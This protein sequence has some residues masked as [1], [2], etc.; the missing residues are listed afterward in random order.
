M[1]RASRA[2]LAA[3]AGLA[4][5]G[6]L[7]LASI[8]RTHPAG[9][10][11]HL[12][13][14]GRRLDPAAETPGSEG[15]F[16]R[17]RSQAAQVSVESVWE[18][19]QQ[20]S[21][22]VYGADDPEYPAAFRH[23]PEPP[24]VIFVQGD[25][26]LL[27]A[28]RR[29]GVVGTRNATAA[30]RAT[31][32][33]LG[34]SLADHGV[35]VVSGLALG[36]DAA[37]HRGLRAGDGMPVGVVANGL[38][39]PYP[40]Q[41]GD[42]WHWVGSRGVLISERPPGCPPE[43]WRFPLRNRLIAALSEVLVVVESRERGGS[44][45]TVEQAL[46]RGVSVMAVPGSPRCR[47]AH[48]TNRLLVEGAGPVTCVEDVLVALGIDH[49]RTAEQLALPLA[50][51]V[52][53]AIELGILRACAACPNTLDMLAAGIGCSVSEVALAVMRLVREGRVQDDDGWFEST[54]SR[55]SPPSVAGSGVG[56][57]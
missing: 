38:D 50:P 29:V 19:C 8:L 6:P 43:P 22:G 28:R 57:P 11:F 36:I 53:D 3:L 14:A 40:R 23:D 24:P 52:G 49:H 44:L 48:G 2:A 17:L 15:L 39:V 51:P 45:L 46:A 54:G 12:L 34:E 31:A 18:A 55:L 1:T 20:H 13:A 56:E 27:D 30:G 47:A 35:A 4:S 32:F 16:D 25:L 9:E 42:L 10:A 26:G 37:V 5:M 21:V 33:E 41:H 7:R